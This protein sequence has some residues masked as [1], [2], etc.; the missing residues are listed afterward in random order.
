MER[1]LLNEDGHGL[2]SGDDDF[3]VAGI[4][5]KLTFWW[6]NPLFSKGHKQKLTL[7]DVPLLPKTE[8]ADQAYKLLEDSLGIGK[9]D[10]TKPP[11]L[12]K[13]VFSALRKPL[14]LNAIFA[15]KVSPF[16]FYFLK[17]LIVYSTIF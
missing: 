9:A 14:L 4:W 6:L 7:S 12:P 15:G 13:A 3:T 8:T 17:K 10:R 16:Y 1:P 5:N 2:T 11:S